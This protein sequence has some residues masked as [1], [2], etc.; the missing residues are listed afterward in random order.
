MIVTSDGCYLEANSI[1]S[2]RATFSCKAES[3]V[4]IMYG[5]LKM[6][7]ALDLG[8]LKCEDGPEFAMEFGNRFIG[9]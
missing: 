3:Y 7:N 2:L 6:K 9:G 8:L 1:E 5:R 4:L